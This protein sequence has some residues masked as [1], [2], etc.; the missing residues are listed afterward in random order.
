M[1]GD[2]THGEVVWVLSPLLGEQVSYE[3]VDTRPR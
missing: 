1:P 3:A 2:E